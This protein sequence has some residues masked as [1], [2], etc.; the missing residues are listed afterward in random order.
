MQWYFRLAYLLGGTL[1]GF[2]GTASSSAQSIEARFS[3]EKANYLVGEPL[4]IT[5]TVRNKT[6]EPIW[7][8][9][10]SPDIAKLLC[11]DFAVEV[12]GAEP[13]DE[14]WGCGFAGS[15]GRG[16]KE[17]PPGKSTILRQLVNQQVHLQQGAYSLHAQTT[18]VVRKQN[19]FDSP[20]IEQ[21]KVFD[22][23]LVEVQHGNENEIESA[24]RPIVT[25]LNNPD[26]TRRAEAAAAITELAPTFL[27]DILIELAKTNFAHSA[28]IAL[29]KADTPKTRAALAQIAIGG[30]DSMVR[31]E[32]ISNLGLTKDLGYLPILFQ[33]MESGNK[34]IQNAA[35]EATGTLGGVTAVQR[36]SAF[37][38]A[39]DAETRIAGAGGLGRTHAREAVPILMRLLLDSDSNV[40]QAAVSNLWLLTHHAAFEGNQWADISTGES[41][42]AVHQ[43]WVR[44]WGNHGATCEI[45][46]MTDC[47]S[48][49][50]LD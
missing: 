3:T 29:R 45:H 49:Q 6:G 36:L 1:L 27:E 47:S 16:L 13:A 46:G 40:R 15:C 21:V 43:R 32:A 48:P 28:I 35:A 34:P 17:V 20:K 44:W 9:F 41:A 19:L 31:I 18:I 5:L 38:S 42:A 11:N 12:P 8:E 14:H 10:Q 33:L 23:L 24:F 26:L 50:P 22:T 37:L 39:G 7:L 2:V 4:F 30:D 25:E